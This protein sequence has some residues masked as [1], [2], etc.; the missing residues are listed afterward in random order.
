MKS[1]YTM[2]GMKH[3]G[4]VELVNSFKGGERI[5]LTREPENPADAN[6]VAIYYDDRKV[7]FVKGTEC[8]ALARDMDAKGLTTLEGVFRVTADRWP[9]VEVDNR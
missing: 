8:A 1:L 5:T 3:Q 7:A 4:A 6:A 9:Q 2:V